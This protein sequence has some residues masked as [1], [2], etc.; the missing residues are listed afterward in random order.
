MLILIEEK[1][2]PFWSI[3]FFVPS[4]M[5][6]FKFFTLFEAH[7]LGE[8]WILI[9]LSW[10]F[11][12]LQENKET[13]TLTQQENMSFLLTLMIPDQNLQN[14]FKMS[15]VARKPFSWDSTF[16]NERFDFWFHSNFSSHFSRSNIEA[17][18][19]TLSVGSSGER[20]RERER[21]INMFIQQ[22][23]IRVY[24]WLFAQSHWR[25]CQEP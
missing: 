4:E 5:D 1:E 6:H 14:Y 17:L 22:R 24:N 16:Q 11:R 15:S 23:I 8:I 2:K 13:S 20:D 21:D 7:Q 9:S 19:R 18:N 25:V 3:T 10:T 12:T